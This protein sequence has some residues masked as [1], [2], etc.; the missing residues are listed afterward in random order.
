MYETR[1]LSSNRAF[2]FHFI[3]RALRYHSPITACLR[4]DVTDTLERID[5]CRAEGQAVSLISYITLASAKTIEAH[6]RL[7]QRI[8]H[9]LF[10]KTVATFDHIT[11]GLLVAR[12]EDGGEEVLIPLMIRDTNTRSLE[13][14]HDI[15]EDAKTGPLNQ[16]GSYQSLK[17]LRRLPK[18]LIGFAQFLSRTSPRYGEKRFATYG[19]SSVTTRDSPAIGGH[20]VASRTTFFPGN[21]REEVL[22]VNGEPAVRKTFFIGLSVDHFMVDGMDLQRAVSTF[23]S[24]M[25]NPDTLLPTSPPPSEASKNT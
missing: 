6:P 15:I 9:G 8:Y 14:I 5:T 17:K 4:I 1:S 16:A 19:L 25:E 12:R 3:R 11:A 7:N 2:I 10:R 21:I 13:E 18:F 23:Q 22:A 24:F 20:T